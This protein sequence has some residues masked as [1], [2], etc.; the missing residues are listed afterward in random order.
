[1]IRRIK[2][3]YTLIVMSSVIL[4]LGLIITA[5]N[6]A[7]YTSINSLLDEKLDMLVDNEGLMPDLPFGEKPDED[8]NGDSDGNDGTSEGDDKDSSGGTDQGENN[9]SSGGSGDSGEGQ[10]EQNGT[11]ASDD[12]TGTGDGTGGQPSEDNGNSGND[13]TSGEGEG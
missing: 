12:L 8:K 13:Q 5:I 2:T 11:G 7:N 9:D 10:G 1:M 6:V 4:V 3:K